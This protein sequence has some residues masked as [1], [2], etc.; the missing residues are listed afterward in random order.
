M[1]QSISSR[2]P[3]K[4]N[5]RS[6]YYRF[7]PSSKAGG[8][9]LF[10]RA[11]KVAAGQASSL[12]IAESETLY[13]G[14]WIGRPLARREDKRLVTGAGRFAADYN[15][16]NDPHLV[17]VRSTRAHARMLATAIS[18]SAVCSTRRMLTRPSAPRRSPSDCAA[19]D[20]QGRHLLGRTRR[21]L[22]SVGREDQDLA[23][24]PVA[25]FREWASGRRADPLLGEGCATPLPSAPLFQEPMRGRRGRSRWRPSVPVG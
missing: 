21:P 6:Q 3:P 8:L 20:Q 25:T 5:V 7:G 23:V 19:G 1:L 9:A 24:G 14:K 4:S 22:K 15:N 18:I 12:T 2:S 11:S 13:N 17:I 16:A 10:I